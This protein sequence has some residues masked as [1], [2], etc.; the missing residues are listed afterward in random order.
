MGRLYRGEGKSARPDGRLAGS[1]SIHSFEMEAERAAGSRCAMPPHCSSVSIC[2]LV[3][4]KHIMME[5]SPH[6]A[7]LHD[8]HFQDILHHVDSEAVVPYNYAHFAVVSPRTCKWTQWN[9]GL[10]ITIVLS[11][12]ECGGHMTVIKIPNINL[13][14]DWHLNFIELKQDEK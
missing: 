8:T 2:A 14:P 11:N 12:V 1:P 5:L 7:V 9:F 13:R 4:L 6:M 10:G 3:N